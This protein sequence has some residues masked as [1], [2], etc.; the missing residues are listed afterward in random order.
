MPLLISTYRHDYP[1]PQE[2]KGHIDDGQQ[3]Q[4]RRNEPCECCDGKQPKQPNVLEQAADCCIGPT[5]KMAEW[6]GIAPMGILIDPRIIPGGENDDDDEENDTIDA[7]QH[8]K[9]NRFLNSI[10]RTDPALFDRIKS[11][12]NDDLLRK[13]DANRLRSTY[14]VDYGGIAEFYGGVYQE[15]TEAELAALKENFGGGGPQD[16]CGYD[17]II[18]DTAKRPVDAV[19]AKKKKVCCPHCII[20]KSA[21][22]WQVS[23]K[24]NETEYM[25]T[26]SR[27][28]RLAM[29]FKINDH[30]K[31]NKNKCQHFM[32]LK[33]AN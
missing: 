1:N 3:Q 11:L 19:L 22:H 9:P 15:E 25:G 17:S 16:P 4:G 23:S 18:K 26:I 6:T 7:C 31:C 20:K 29:K 21:G 8:D 27:I 10:N 32:N 2:L 12:N 14:Q 5:E 13:I 33:D 28:G 30:N 24:V